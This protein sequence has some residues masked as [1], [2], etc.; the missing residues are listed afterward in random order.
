MSVYSTVKGAEDGAQTQS[1]VVALKDFIPAEALALYLFAVGILTP[2]ADATKAD[3]GLVKAFCFVIGLLSVAAITLTSLDDSKAQAGQGIHKLRIS[4]PNR[5]R[6]VL[7]VLAWSAFTGYVLATLVP[8]GYQVASVEVA[9]YAVVL[10]ALWAIVLPG[11]AD[12]LGVRRMTDG[13]SAA[14]VGQGQHAT[15]PP[16][17]K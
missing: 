13:D 12:W 7:I 16:T 4:E 17:A 8:T 10:A 3:I 9:R 5:R 14:P 2:A 11:V 15:D 1:Y 6:I